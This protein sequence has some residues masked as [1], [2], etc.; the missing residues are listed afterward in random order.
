MTTATTAINS[1][2][3]RKRI[4]CSS[5]R[6][7]LRKLPSGWQRA[8]RAGQCSASSG[9]KRAGTAGRGQR[10]GSAVPVDEQALPLPEQEEREQDL[11]RLLAAVA[12][13]RDEPADC[14]GV[15]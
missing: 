15:E 13:L 7:A 11:R 14:L 5:P 9:G 8:A 6:R 3:G 10:C 4:S 12:R 2:Y 1:E